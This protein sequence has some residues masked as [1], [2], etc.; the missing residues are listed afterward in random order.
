[1]KTLRF[2]RTLAFAVCTLLVTLLMGS[3]TMAQDWVRVTDGRT[4]ANALLAGNEA[5]GTRLYV[6]RAR[7]ESGLHLGKARANAREAYIPYGGREIA[8]SDY[9]VYVGTGTWQDVRPGQRVPTNAIAGGN[10]TDGTPLYVARATIDGGIHPGKAKGGEAWIPYGGQERYSVPF[11]VLVGPTVQTVKQPTKPDVTLGHTP[12][13]VD[14]RQTERLNLSGNYYLEG[15]GGGFL[16]AIA[17]TNTGGIVKAQ[18]ERCPTCSSSTNKWAFIRTND[19][20]YYVVISNNS[21]TKLGWTVYNLPRIRDPRPDHRGEIQGGRFSETLVGEES[22]SS[23]GVERYFKWKIEK[24]PDGKLLFRIKLNNGTYETMGPFIA[25]PTTAFSACVKFDFNSPDFAG[26]TITNPSLSNAFNSQPT[27]LT[28]VPWWHYLG[29]DRPIVPSMPLGGDYWQDIEQYYSVITRANR[30][31]INTFENKNNLSQ[32]AQGETPT[33]I[34]LSDP[35]YFCN[36]PISFMIGGTNDISNEKIEILQKIDN[37]EV[38]ATTITLND[39]LYKVIANYTRTGHGHDVLRKEVIDSPEL[40]GKICRIRIS[41]NSATG[42]ICVDEIGFGPNGTSEAPPAPPQIPTQRPLFGFVDMHTH[43]MS[44]LGFGKKLIHGAP[45]VGSLIPTGTRYMGF[46]AFKWDCNTADE[47]AGSIGQALGCCNATHGGAGADNDCGNYIRNIVIGQMESA[48]KAQSAHGKDNPSFINWPKYNDI[49]HQ[50]MWVDW[51]SRAHQGG[52]RVMVALAVN[53][54]TLGESVNG[55]APL[56][57]K[58]SSDLQ[59]AELKSFVNR[60]TDF[61]EISYSPQD[62]R[63]INQLGKLAVIIGVELD[64]IGNFNSVPN[65]TN[66]AISA[67]IQRLYN[68]GVRYI[69]PVHVIDNKF[70]GTAAYEHLFNRSNRHLFGRYWDLICSTPEDKI[71]YRF[72]AGQFWDRLPVDVL[73]SIRFGIFDGPPTYPNCSTGLMNSRSLTNEGRYAIS[74]MMK[75]GMIIDIDHM[76]QRTA[77]AAISLADQFQYPVNSG[78]NGVRGEGGSENSRTQAQLEKLSR[79]G[80]L[81]GVGWGDNN[82]RG[83]LSNYRT[84]LTAMGGKQTAFGTDINGLVNGPSKGATDVYSS[85]LRMCTTDSK[86]WDYREGGVAHYGLFPDFLQDLKNLGMSAQER[87]ALFSSAEYFAQMWEKCERQKSQVR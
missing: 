51:I 76:S 66:E 23:G 42:H 18:F 5:D 78:H 70:G 47:R 49:T 62:L 35:F 38:G 44:Y 85:G 27:T 10:E 41:D 77:N 39:G 25:H 63:R 45:D 4:P 74:E 28:R 8:V 24:Q 83:F 11:Q 26:W 48:K 57:D 14:L 54:R 16:I 73:G 40:V 55:D 30:S 34:L 43:P 68:T 7:H 71:T 2:L 21:S 81:M 67:E 61:M 87:T 56:D 86:T 53:N 12:I 17:T 29:N 84:A 36:S 58:G 3:P 60:H 72:D 59:I 52:L 31:Y 80:G 65:L 32:P 9:E 75:R 64:D 6:A 46:D 1:M 50:Q 19:S 79:L 82:S 22:E 69:F 33:G 20:L 37:P 15:G 13:L